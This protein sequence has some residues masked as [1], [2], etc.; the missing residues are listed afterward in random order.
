MYHYTY[1]ITVSNPTD[2][3]RF[4]IGVRSSTVKPQDD[5][6]F[7][8]CKEFKLW[9]VANGIDGLEKQVLATWAT[10]EEALLHE[11]LL[12]DCFDVARNPEFWNQ[13]KQKA[14]LF[15]TTGTVQSEEL[16]LRK[17]LKTK[18]RAKS[19]EHKTK[20]SFALKGFKKNEAHCRAISEAKK[21]K[22]SPL[23]GISMN[24][25]VAKSSEHKRKIGEANKGKIRSLE[26]RKKASEI[27]KG[28]APAYSYTRHE[29]IECPYCNKIGMKANMKRYHFNNCK[30]LQA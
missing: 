16:K 29:N 21:G 25:G 15:D 19:E 2:V 12:H 10:R 9:Q 1:Q 18:G 14:V 7:G 8:S 13:A 26:M 5:I 27:R 28:I 3:R 30:E 11:I 23:R 22:P 24:K 17:S 6:Y 4:Y 20:I